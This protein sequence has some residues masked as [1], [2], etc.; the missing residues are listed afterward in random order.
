MTSEDSEGR[1]PED[2][3]RE[4]EAASDGIEQRPAG[5]V[6]PDVEPED[7]GAGAAPSNVVPL[8]SGGEEAGRMLE[9]MLFA[10]R[11][12][13]SVADLARQLP[14]G[15]DVAELVARL[16]ES[17]AGRGVH[18]VEIG[19]A[20]AFRTAPD[21]AYLF[22]R[23]QE[24]ERRLS[25]AALETLA[26]IAYH[27]PVSRAEIEE[28]RG[29]T[30][31]KGT[32]DVLMEEGWVRIKGRRRVPGRPAVYGTTEA[33]LEQFGLPGLE[34]LPGL[35]ELKAAGLLEALP[36]EGFLPPPGGG[37]EELDPPEDE[38]EEEPSLFEEPEEAQAAGEPSNEDEPPLPRA[39]NER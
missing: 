22:E 31:S 18:L 11:E 28:I 7:E 19:G 25:K 10:A 14:A 24:E 16:R 39:A 33:F 26:I 29:V 38:A 20:F 37:G 13:L 27:Q 36:P 34:D 17:Y 8:P 2:A 30:V 23:E 6:E 21:L 5:Y 9:A 1:M 35:A 15:L 32:L 4:P 3:G 12:P